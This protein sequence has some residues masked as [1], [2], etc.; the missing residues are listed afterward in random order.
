MIGRR[1]QSG[2]AASGAVSA[3]TPENSQ[4]EPGR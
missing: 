3:E 2:Q 4:I 1:L